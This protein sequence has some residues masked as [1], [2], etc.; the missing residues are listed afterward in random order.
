M[1]HY[2]Y[3]GKYYALYKLK[4]CMRILIED[5]MKQFIIKSYD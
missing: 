4:L 3:I 2:R 1:Y 5:L